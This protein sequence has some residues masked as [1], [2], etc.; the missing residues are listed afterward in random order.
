MTPTR[1]PRRK[2]R[3]CSRSTADNW[4]PWWRATAICSR[5]HSI[6]TSASSRTAS[7]NGSRGPGRSC[8]PSPGCA[9]GA[10]VPAL[11]LDRYLKA[12]SLILRFRNL[13][14][15]GVHSV[16]GKL[17]I[18][19]LLDL[20]SVSDVDVSRDGRRIAFV[21]RPSSY[22]K[23]TVPE[24]SIWVSD[25]GGDPRQV[26]RGPGSDSL[27]SWSPDG[28]ML[29]FASD[30]DHAGLLSPYLLDFTGEARPAGRCERFGGGDPLV[31][32]RL[33][34]RRAGGRSRLRPRRRSVGDQDRGQGR[35]AARSGRA[36]AQPVLA[37][38]LAHRARERRDDRG[39]PR[40]RQRLG[41]RLDR[42]GR[43]RC[44]DHQ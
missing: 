15:E 1:S 28:S 5:P 32:R 18:E 30:R 20:R 2:P 11:E 12:V 33:G 36:P 43:R 35:R 8:S 10:P 6:S 31:G 19:D 27:P 34:P 41:V 4:M 26:T 39:E 17:T 37:E 13:R 25:G 21:V 23:G 24:G 22:E 7:R 29:A 42:R 9:G 14:S 3:W 44:G 38:A 40:G 16:A